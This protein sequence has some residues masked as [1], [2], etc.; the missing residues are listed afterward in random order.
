[1]AIVGLRQINLRQRNDDEDTIGA[2]LCLASIDHF[3]QV[4]GQTGI[5]VSYQ[6]C[7]AA[8]A[9]TPN[10]E[11]RG[12]RAFQ[13]SAYGIVFGSSRLY[14]GVDPDFN[15]IHDN[16]STRRTFSNSNYEEHA[17]QSAIR[18]AISQG[19]TLWAHGDHAHI[20]V[21]FEPCPKCEPWLQDRPENYFVHYKEPL[22]NQESIIKLKK[23]VR[24]NEYGR[25]TERKVNF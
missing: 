25:I 20:Y 24:K 17:E 8:L 3:G 7:N 11:Y 6:S 4:L 16:L 23:D 1:M 15:T 19:C 21:D 10:F 22:D 5:G 9:V 14:V 2:Y 12:V 18:I 13:G